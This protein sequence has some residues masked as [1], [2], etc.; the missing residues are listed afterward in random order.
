MQDSNLQNA[1][2][3]QNPAARFAIK[4]GARLNLQRVVALSLSITDEPGYA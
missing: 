2:H 4:L 3:Y 1:Q